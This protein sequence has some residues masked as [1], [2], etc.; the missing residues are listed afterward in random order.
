ME[1]FCCVVN[2]SNRSHD[3]GRKLHNGTSFFKF[4]AVKQRKWKYSGCGVVEKTQPVDMAAA[5]MCH[6]KEEQC[7]Q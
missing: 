3:S 2:C 4:P 5:M 7:Q 1:K 6:E